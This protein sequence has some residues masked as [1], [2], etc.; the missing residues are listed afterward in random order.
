MKLFLFPCCTFAINASCAIQLKANRHLYLG[1]FSFLNAINLIFITLSLID[2]TI[3]FAK[4]FSLASSIPS[5]TE[6]CVP[7]LS[8][9][10]HN[11][12]FFFLKDKVIETK[13]KRAETTADET[14]NSS[15]Y[16]LPPSSVLCFSL[17]RGP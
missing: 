17:T 7:A 9:D 5:H 15:F 10:L 16:S 12:V 13:D 3:F 8:S 2:V 11:S 14:L 1:L 6:R 4:K